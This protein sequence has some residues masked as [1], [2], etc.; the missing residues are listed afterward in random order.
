[1]EA[2]LDLGAGHWRTFVSV[3]FPLTWHGALSGI[4]IVFIPALGAFYIP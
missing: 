2:S 4:I 1:M 3:V